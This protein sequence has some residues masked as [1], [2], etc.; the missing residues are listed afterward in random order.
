MS[1]AYC[2]LFPKAVLNRL[3]SQLCAFSKH[4]LNFMNVGTLVGGEGS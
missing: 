3:F 4:D 1:S 2:L